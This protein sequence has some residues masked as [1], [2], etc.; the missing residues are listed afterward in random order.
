MVNKSSAPFPCPTEVVFTLLCGKWKLP[1]LGQLRQRPF[2]YTELLDRIPTLS[3]KMLTK[4]LRELE[5]SGLVVRAVSHTG[6]IYGLSDMGRSL[7]PVV[8]ALR[9]WG[10]QNGARLKSPD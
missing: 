4:R 9:E 5:E 8:D 3:E 6:T 7:K 1:I 10:T 2:R